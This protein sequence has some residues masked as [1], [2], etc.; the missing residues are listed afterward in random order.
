MALRDAINR[1]P[2]ITTGA[3]AGLIVVALASIIWTTFGSGTTGGYDPHGKA[4]FTADEGASFVVDSADKRYAP[5]QIGGKDSLLAHVFTCDGSAR[6]V[7]YV[8]RI[9]ADAA[10]TLK[11]LKGATVDEKSPSRDAIIAAGREV[12]RPQET[13]WVKANTTEGAAIIEVKCPDGKSYATEVS[14]DE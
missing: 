12:R 9:S 13:Q 14:A 2:A 8:E 10:K 1:N 3:T 6:F 5:P 7:G 11:S 4:F